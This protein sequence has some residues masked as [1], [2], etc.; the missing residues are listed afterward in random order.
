MRS[1]WCAARSPGDAAPDW[2]ERRCLIV[3]RE[4]WKRP[5]SRRLFE[6]EDAMCRGDEA[7]NAM[8]RA[9]T[10]RDISVEI[11]EVPSLEDCEPAKGLGTEG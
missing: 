1:P 11:F 9:A 7:L 10:E 6:S 5:R 8:N 2:R 4:T 3:N